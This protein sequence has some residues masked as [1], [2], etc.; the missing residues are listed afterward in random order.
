MLSIETVQD[1]AKNLTSKIMDVP[2]RARDLAG[3]LVAITIIDNTPVSGLIE[4]AA[5]AA[6]EA[7]RG[8]VSA[9]LGPDAS[10]PV[11]SA[12]AVEAAGCTT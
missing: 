7:Q 6:P 5:N 1:F 9:S 8:V 3:G 2:T 4:E 11:T 10:A 12:N